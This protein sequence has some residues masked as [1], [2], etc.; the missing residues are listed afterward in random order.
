MQN[1]T[2]LNNYSSMN[3]QQVWDWIDANYLLDRSKYI[4][5]EELPKFN[6]FFTKI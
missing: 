5:T 3:P 1:K 4:E 2:I 6:A